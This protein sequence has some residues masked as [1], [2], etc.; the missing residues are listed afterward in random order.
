MTAVPPD[1]RA[2][3]AD[4]APGVAQLVAAVDPEVVVVG[5]EVLPDGE[6]F[7]TALAGELVRTPG[8]GCRAPPVCGRAV[9]LGRDAVS[10]GAVARSL[11]TARAERMGRGVGCATEPTLATGVCQPVQAGS[12][13]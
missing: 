12:T 9:G 4:V 3:A 5:G 1:V 10:R 13:G 11:A 6:E 7:C 8:L 2:L